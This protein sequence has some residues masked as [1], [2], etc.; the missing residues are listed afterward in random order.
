MKTLR[1]LTLLVASGLLL[2]A[3]GE[4]PAAQQAG[5][6]APAT[7]APAAPAAVPAGPQ[8]AVASDAADLMALQARGT[9]SLENVVDLATQ[10]PSPGNEPNTY[11]AKHDANYRLIGFATDSEAGAVPSKVE[12]L[13]HGESQSF[14]LP[15]S[16]GLE[17]PDVAAFFK[18]PALANSGYQADAGFANVAGGRY[19]VFMVNTFG[20]QRVL[21]PTHQTLIV[22]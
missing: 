17:R 3:C 14:S 1:N 12:M 15:A 10:A 19:E 8:F 22:N 20:D 13:L 2:A 6:A 9:C 16:E 7:G 5:A 4:R 11:S 18:K 21:C